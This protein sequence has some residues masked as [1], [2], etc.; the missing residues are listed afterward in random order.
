MSRLLT[1]LVY[2]LLQAQ[3]TI[4]TAIKYEYCIIRIWKNGKGN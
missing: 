4:K 3:L 2:T 1:L